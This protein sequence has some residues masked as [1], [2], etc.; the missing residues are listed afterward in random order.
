ME[1]YRQELMV[2][3]LEP[4]PELVEVQALM[5]IDPADRERLK[6]DISKDGIRDAIKVYKNGNKYLILGG[7][8]RWR[9][10]QELGIKTVPVEIYHLTEEER[11]DLVIKDNLNRRHLTR[12]QKQRLIEY[13]LKKEPEQSDR[14][15]AKKTS[16]DHKTV[17][18]IRNK[19]QSTG[20]IPRLEKRIGLDGKSRKAEVIGSPQKVKPLQ[21]IAN[22]Q[23]KDH[24]FKA[25]DI[26]NI[27]LNSS[28][29]YFELRKISLLS[30][31]EC[32]RLSDK[33]SRVHL[34]KEIKQLFKRF[35]V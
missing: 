32:F 12:E 8:N 21:P 26:A 22:I 3:V 19:L 6:E 10:A 5:P 7:Y 34:V 30:L 29:D 15:I 4:S 1:V 18:T 16:S 11:R 27:I 23:P 9:I 25:N 31:E 2:D 13:F 28:F 17:G 20:E 35:G 24:N 33:T 14:V